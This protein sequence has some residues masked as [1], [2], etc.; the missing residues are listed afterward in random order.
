[1]GNYINKMPNGTGLEA[2]GKADAIASVPGV[3]E[4]SDI[5]HID[6][7]KIPEDKILV[8]VATNGHSRLREEKQEGGRFANFI[9]ET[10][11]TVPF[12]PTFDAAMVC[13]TKGEF[14]HVLQ[15]LASGDVR[16]MRFFLVPRDDVRTMAD[17][18]LE[19][20]YEKEKAQ[21]QS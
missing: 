14:R 21:A 2:L 19:S 6:Y 10:D 20:E 3:T 12:E 16:P 11:P 7:D 15:C 8:V 13:D 5:R 1:M 17:F 9:L 18:P 4:I